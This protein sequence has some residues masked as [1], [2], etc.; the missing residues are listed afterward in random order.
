MGADL[1]EA[2]GASVASQKTVICLTGDGS[3]MMNLQEL[4]T[5]HHYNLPVKIV[6]FSNDGYNAIRQT[7]KNFFNGKCIGCTPESGV[8]FPDFHSVA[9]TFGFKYKCCNCNAEVEDSLKWLFSSEASVLLEVKQRLDDPVI[10]KVMTRLLDDG[11]YSTPA[12]QDMYPFLDKDDYD[13]LMF[14]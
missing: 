7:A 1:P 5:I 10:P 13:E 9:D 4:Q 11:S 6:I 3:I 8:S 12:I 14:W 2:I